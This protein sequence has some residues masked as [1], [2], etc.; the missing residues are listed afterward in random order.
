M[1]AL[2]SPPLTGTGS[3]ANGFKQHTFS[4]F[5]RCNCTYAHDKYDPTSLNGTCPQ[6]Y[7][8]PYT[9]EGG[10][11]GAANH[12]V[13][14]FTPSSE[15]DWMGYSVRSD[16]YRYTVYV[17]WDGA[18]L[19][20]HWNDT[21]AEE[22]YD[23]SADDSIDFDGPVSEPVNLNLPAFAFIHTSPSSL[24]APVLSIYYLLPA[25]ELARS[26]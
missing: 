14:L 13:C 4:Q 15:F 16:Q 3:A 7:K 17:A 2:L 11:T 20:P 26:G 9:S 10:A 8:N 12:H 23:H 1:P 25:G 5:P 18:A 22:L 19:R 6:Q 24:Q 21:Y